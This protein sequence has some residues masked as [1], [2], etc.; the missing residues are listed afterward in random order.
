MASATRPYPFPACR[1]AT[2]L[3]PLSKVCN[4]VKGDGNDAVLKRLRWLMFSRKTF[5]IAPFLSTASEGRGGR[6][7]YVYVR[8]G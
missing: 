3:E 1:E 4:L 8:R 6:V 2:E 7:Y 5:S